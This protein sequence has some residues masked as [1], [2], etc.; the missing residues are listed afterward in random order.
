MTPK[1]PKFQILSI[2]T[3]N[4]DFIAH[5]IGNVKPQRQEIHELPK[6]INGFNFQLTYTPGRDADT[7]RGDHIYTARKKNSQMYSH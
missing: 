7:W 4:K 3:L 6:L 2:K 1:S 5:Y